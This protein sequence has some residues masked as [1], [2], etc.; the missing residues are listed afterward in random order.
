MSP[1]V[2]ISILDMPNVEAIMHTLAIL[3]ALLN[4][5]IIDI[6]QNLQPLQIPLHAVQTDLL[7]FLAPWYR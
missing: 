2:C 1:E 5:G 6:R 4:Q 7:L 3:K